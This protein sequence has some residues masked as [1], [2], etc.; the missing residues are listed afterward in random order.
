MKKLQVVSLALVALFAFSAMLATTASAAGTLLPEWLI[1]GV[2]VTTLTSVII[3]GELLLKDTGVSAGVKCSGKFIG[4]VGPS[5]EDEITSVQSLT[6]ATITLAA[7]LT[8]CVKEENC[9]GTPSV[10]PEELP[11][12]TLLYL[13][14]STGKYRDLTFHAGYSVTCTILG[15]KVEDNCT[16][17]NSS[18]EIVNPAG[19]AES[20]G[21][22]TPK[23]TCSAGGA[24]TAFLEAEPGNKVVN[25]AL[26]PVIASSE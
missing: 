20:I 25:L 21:E 12:H 17:T 5:G 19:G 16:T 22:I 11:W 8:T 14:E 24:G 15:I 6:G 13:V 3:E 4:S 2:G 7:P 18:A 23:G 10:A 9:G 1:K 26:E